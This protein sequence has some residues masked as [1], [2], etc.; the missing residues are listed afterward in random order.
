L[1]FCVFKENLKMKD[2]KQSGDLHV[3]ALLQYANNVIAT[4]REPFLVLDKNLKVISTNQAF[5][6]TFKV[7]EKD[8]LGRSLRDLGNKQWDI[9]KLLLLLREI[10][11]E[12]QVVKDYEVAHKFEQIGERTMV[13]NASHHSDGIGARRRR[14]RRRRRRVNPLGY[15]RHYRA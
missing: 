4:L 14:R 2:K 15:R 10:L 3:E 9:P 12:K 8:T 6:T 1:G 11:P 13:L 7:V 5:Y